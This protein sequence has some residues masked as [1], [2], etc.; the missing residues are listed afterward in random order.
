MEI[1]KQLTLKLHTYMYVRLECSQFDASI[2]YIL[3]ETY[4][5]SQ[6]KGVANY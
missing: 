4:R 2:Y 1:I 3:A 5:V 6:S